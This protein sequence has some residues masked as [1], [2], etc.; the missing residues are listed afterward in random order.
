M[1][2]NDPFYSQYNL[3][4]LN[5]VRTYPIIPGDCAFGPSALSSTV[6]AYIDLYIVYS[7]SKEEND[8]LRTFNNGFIKTN[9]YDVLPELEGCGPPRHDCFYL[10]DSR[11]N[12]TPP[13][14]LLHSL[15]LRAHNR[16]AREL[17]KV[18]PTWS[19]EKLFVES[20]RLTIAIHQHIVFHEWLPLLLGKKAILHF[21]VITFNSLF[22]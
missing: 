18:N 21:S 7:N 9:E 20:R 16:N 5:F 1:P 4:C 19:D 14:A 15:M 13:L 2:R 3:T 11:I 10:G 17:A 22:I 12:Q 6:T 8:G